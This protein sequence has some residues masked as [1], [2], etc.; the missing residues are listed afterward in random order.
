MALELHGFADASHRAYAAVIY[1]RIAGS[2][3]DYTVTLL[4]AKSKVAPIKTVSIPHL[5]LC[6]TVLLTRLMIFVLKSLNRPQIQLYGWT[7]ST[8]LAWLKGHPSRWTTFVANRVSEVQTSLP[9]ARWNHVPSKEN[10]ADC[11]SRGLSPNE[12]RDYKLWWHGPNWLR[13][14]SDTW[15]KQS[16]VL[17]PSVS[18]LESTIPESRKTIACHV[19]LPVEWELPNEFSSWTRLIR[20]TARVKR[21]I[22][23]LRK[24]TDQS[25][26]SD[27]NLSVIELKEASLFW[28]RYV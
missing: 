26:G 19:Q 9:S 21:F 2:S 15:P 7:D 17:H 16:S 3:N 5:E 4:T 6:A 10:P 14:S 13:S 25:R 23:H 18:N 24:R 11:A 28:F 8:A 20:V 12:F 22:N 1:L 27:L